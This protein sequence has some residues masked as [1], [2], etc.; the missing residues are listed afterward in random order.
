[1]VLVFKSCYSFLAWKNYSFGVET[2][3]VSKKKI[4]QLKMDWYALLK[5][6]ASD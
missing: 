5:T 2:K 3:E 1:M 4:K 6:I